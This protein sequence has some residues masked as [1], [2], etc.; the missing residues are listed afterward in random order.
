MIPGMYIY[1][2]SILIKTVILEKFGY[3]WLQIKCQGMT[4]SVAQIAEHNTSLKVPVHGFC[5]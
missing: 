4:F 2:Y 3:M 1:I 5:D